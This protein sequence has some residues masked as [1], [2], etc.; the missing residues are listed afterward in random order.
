M[1]AHLKKRTTST[2][3]INSIPMSI[4]NCIT[5]SIHTSI[6]VIN[7]INTAFVLLIVSIL[8]SLVLS[9]SWAFFA[10]KKKS[11]WISLMVYFFDIHRKKE[12]KKRGL[13]AKTEPRTYAVKS[14]SC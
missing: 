5:I 1:K 8:H 12:K 2:H 7:S 6:R 13:S 9:S 4:P 3:T 11:P 10:V 14:Y